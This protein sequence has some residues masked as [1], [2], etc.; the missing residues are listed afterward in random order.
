[1]RYITAIIFSAITTQA[2]VSFQHEVLP[3]LT[4]QGCN[5]GTCH[6]SPSGKGGFALSLFAFDAK[7]DHTVLTKD[8][9]SRRI[10][11]N[12][13]ALSLLLRKP[14]NAISHRGGLK[15]PQSS[16]EY[17]ILHDWIKEGCLNDTG[18]GT[19]CTGI[20]LQ[21]EGSTLLHWPNPISRLRVKAY[22][23]DDTARDI[24]HLVQFTSSDEAI[25]VVKANGVVAGVNRGVAAVMV[26]Y[27][28]HV[29][30][31]AFTFVK[32]MDGFQWTNP[33]AANYVD[34]HVH[35][36]LKQMQFTPS[37][38][39]T[40]A[41]FVRRVY[42]DVL[43]RLPSPHESRAFFADNN[44]D[45]RKTLIDQLLQRP[46]YALFWAQKW[47]DLLRLDPQQVSATGTHKFHRWLVQAY[48]KNLPY[49]EFTRALLTASGST[50]T[51][52]PANYYRTAK[53]SKDAL[54][55]T[56][57]LFMGSRL[58]CAKCHNHPYERWTQD[59]Y[60]GLA[61]VFQRVQRKPG[62]RK[63][64]LFISSR[65]DGEVTQPRTGKTMQPY[66]PGQGYVEVPDES[67]RRAVFASWLIQ[68]NNPWFARVEAN[69]IWAAVMGRGIV[70]PIDDFRDSNPP[71]N[72]PLLKALA[73]DFTKHQFDRQHLL[74][75]IL[76]S[77]TYQTSAKPVEAKEGDER[78]FSHYPAHRLKAEQLLDAINDVTGV[79]ENFPG[80]PIGTRATALPGPFLKHPLLKTF[81]MPA[82]TTA[83]AC[84]RP[85]DPQL[86]HA[87]ELMNGK[88]IHDKIAHP[89]GRIK[90]W[91][92]KGTQSEKIITELYM[93]ALSRMPTRKEREAINDY[94]ADKPTREE[95]L[96]DLMWAVMNMNEFLFQH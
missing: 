3:V 47:G 1:M 93:L 35:A 46:E 23:S 33:P 25:A 92:N 78:F 38:L 81:G 88:F 73:E 9:L 74:R 51:R 63:D 32:P 57:Q 31:V 48:E 87:L 20:E 26:R 60:Y 10:D 83:C 56:T 6:G 82:R 75:T 77:H 39:C 18:S 21:P 7:S 65:G 91:L 29:R 69:R 52:P 15:L 96:A 79:P 19:S 36:K 90:Q 28:E 86:S 58:A 64:E 70:E 61:A 40:D 62:T 68:P 37:G 54:E 13:P 55:T 94:L 53:D 76:N 95:G 42:L 5:A 34:I 85:T 67:D 66:L 17:K 27:L 24:T 11:L 8:Y 22:F 45:K 89:K 43:G 49:D 84:E 16:R 2:A 72:A 41:E 12:D 80:L 4:R 14:S 71:I 44:P 59:N 50:F 30:A